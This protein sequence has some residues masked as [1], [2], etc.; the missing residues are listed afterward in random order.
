MATLRNDRDKLLQGAE[1]RVE[2]VYAITVSPTTA[3]LEAAS[4]GT[5]LD[6]TKGNANIVVTQ[7]G[8]IVTDEWAISI[9]PSGLT[10]TELNGVITFTGF[11]VENTA[12]SGFFDITAVKG[13][14]TLTTRYDVLR[15]RRPASSLRLNPESVTLQVNS[16]GVISDIAPAKSVISITAAEQDV[17]DQWSVS[18]TDKYLTSTL[19]GRN[20]AVTAFSGG[21]GP[22]EANTVLKLLGEGVAE[23]TNIRDYSFYNRSMTVAGTVK[24]K[25]VKSVF[26]NTS[27][28]F[29]GTV[30]SYLATPVSTD[31]DFNRAEDYTIEGSFW[32]D[33]SIEIPSIGRKIILLKVVFG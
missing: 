17:F 1:I 30:G 7:S 5:V 24:Y 10:G 6:I 21:S 22:A 4:N 28:F 2:Y 19:V 18:K 11:A 15:I 13:S 8:E 32:L 9:T 26:G 27:I 20:I 16:L 3:I 25:N 31:F 33:P 14:V 23:S 12:D 29:D